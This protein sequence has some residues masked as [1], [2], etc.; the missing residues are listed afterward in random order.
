M[1][2]V[3][4]LQDSPLTPPRPTTT[5]ARLCLVPASRCQFEVFS[6]HLSLSSRQRPTRQ[7]NAVKPGVNP[8]WL[9][10]NRAIYLPVRVPTGR[11]PTHKNSHQLLEHG[12]F[13][14]RRLC[15]RLCDLTDC[16]TRSLMKWW[17]WSCVNL[18]DTLMSWLRVR[19]QRLQESLCIFNPLTLT[20]VLP[21]G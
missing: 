12:F 11:P 19:W 2:H 18:F 10:Y 5:A 4:T 14:I 6:L 15:F 3:V 13:F 9:R 16:S 8:H 1:S 7:R 17:V 21:H 20:A